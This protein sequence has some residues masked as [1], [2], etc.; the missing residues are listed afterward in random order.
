MYTLYILSEM[1]VVAAT[2]SEQLSNRKH[3]VFI[4]RYIFF[5]KEEL[6]Q[7]YARKSCNLVATTLRM[8][9]HNI[10]HQ[11]QLSP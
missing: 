3:V 8:V 7:K 10:I 11:T 1:S 2:A 4:M 5:T 6:I 9:F